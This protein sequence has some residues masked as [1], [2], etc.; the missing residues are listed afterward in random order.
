MKNI[1][2]ILS[3]LVA[4]KLTRAQTY[5]EWV[6]QKE[7]QKKYLI[8]QIL[9]FKTYIG[10]VQQGYSIANKGLNTIKDIKNG[11]FNLH[12]NFFKSLNTVNPQVKKYSK[13]AAII[14]MQISIAKHV[15]N[16]I[17]DCRKTKQ[18]TNTE[19][20][21]LQKV[22]NNVLDE[23]A[24]NLNNLI[25]L[26]TDGEQQMKDDERIKQIDKLYI[27]MQ[28]KQVFVQS[29]SNS[30]KKLSVQRRNDRYDIQIE[31]K[32]NGLK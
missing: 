28:E 6:R 9:A 10:N 23:C 26:I 3:L 31:K 4:G 30:A 2:I 19:L 8:E 15:H 27:D 5:D 1:I 21:Y 18:L 14:A 16:T 20:D 11:D 17:R 13:I 29:F 32:L 7:T 12:D 22:F 24:K 25:A